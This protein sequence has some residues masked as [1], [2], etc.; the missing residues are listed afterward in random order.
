MRLVDNAAVR[1]AVAEFAAAPGQRRYFDVLRACMWGEL[2]FDITGSDAFSGDGPLRAGSRLRIGGGTG[3]DGRPAL[4]AFT[5]QSEISRLHPPGTN[6]QSLVTP[7]TEALELARRQDDPWL[8]LDPAGPT[9]ALAAAEID[10]ALRNPRNEPLKT[11]VAALAAGRAE[12]AEV[13]RL[14]RAD[15]PLLVG[16]DESGPDAPVI[17]AIRHPDGSA[18]L[19]AF[20]SGPEV[21]AFTPSDVTASM[22]TAEVLGMVRQRGYRGLIID[23]CGPSA[24]FSAAEL[25]G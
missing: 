8:Y 7:A 20:T 9:C 6:V 24:S 14:L 17:R 15:G 12:R 10:F 25:C 23:P 18:T 16:A 22:T 19:F 1:R 5:R 21:L 3:P 11:A 13:L 2:L 4:F